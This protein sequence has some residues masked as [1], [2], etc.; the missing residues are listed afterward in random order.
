MKKE[1]KLGDTV[2]YSAKFLKSI[3]DVSHKS[4]S[5]RG[6]I[7]SLDGDSNF[8]IAQIDGDFN[9]GVNVKNLS[10][11]KNRLVLDE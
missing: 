11:V 10:L 7:I 1:F 2:A 9:C 5:K 3:C 6:K 8:M 4:A